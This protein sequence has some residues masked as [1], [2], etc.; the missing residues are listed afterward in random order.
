MLAGFEEP[1]AGR[2]RISG[3]E[4]QGVPPHKRNVNTVFQHY[5]LFPHMS[6]A[7]NVAYGLRQK[8]VERRRSRR[9]SARCSRW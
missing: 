8:K 4:V 9:R 1:T 2:I 3:Q 5:A 7:E 6:V